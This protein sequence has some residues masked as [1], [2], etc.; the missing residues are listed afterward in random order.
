MGLATGAVLAACT[1]DERPPSVRLLLLLTVDTLRADHLGA[2]G[3]GRDLTPRIDALAS[4]SLLFTAA[5]A[6]ASHTLPSVV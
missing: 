3:S 6:P 1:P 2:Y 4:E 5:Y